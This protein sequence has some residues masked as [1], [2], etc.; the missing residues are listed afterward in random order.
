MATKK[1]IIEVEEGMTNCCECP[2]GF[3]CGGSSFLDCCDYNL[4]TIK[5]KEYEDK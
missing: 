3:S 1:F 5:I 2:E 4:A